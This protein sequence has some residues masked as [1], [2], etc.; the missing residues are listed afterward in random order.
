MTRTD[1]DGQHVPDRFKYL[2]VLLVPVRGVKHMRANLFT[3][4]VQVVL[5][6]ASSAPTN[7]IANTIY[8]TQQSQVLAGASD[9]SEIHYSYK[10][11][12]PRFYIPLIEIDLGSNGAGQLRF[13]RGESDEVL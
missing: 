13:R 4:V 5:L 10:F 2:L 12:N 1:T 11:E 3:S 6:I 8:S 7:L 9:S